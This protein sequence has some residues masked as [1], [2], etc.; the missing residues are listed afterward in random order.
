MSSAEYTRS[1]NAHYGRSNLGTTILDALREAGKDPDNLSYEDLAPVDQFH[2]R[3][4]AATRELAQLAGL[5]GGEKVLDMGGGLGGPART[6]AAEFNCHVTVLDLT[7]EF[8]RAGEMLTERTRLS[9]RV[10]FKV[11]NALDMPF[12]DSSFDV[13]WSQH[14]SMNISDKERLYA[15]AHRVL[16]PGGR[17][18]LHEIMAG[19]V[20]PVHFPAPWA[21][22][23]DISFLRPVE[24]MRTLIAE[25]GFR[26]LVWENTTSISLEWFRER[27]AAS[28]AAGGPPSVGLHLLL[29]NT[30]AEAFTNNL[31]NLEEGRTVII[32]GIFQRL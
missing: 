5:H 6:L 13:V 9:D 12:A 2:S 27:S 8:C 23:P 17:L 29:G 18:A 7:E 21:R 32:E 31:R 20:Q 25:S 30:F 15:Q 28:K 1:V 11:G 10:R 14:S 3:G 16:K 22:T 24:E 4:R 19:E 26:E